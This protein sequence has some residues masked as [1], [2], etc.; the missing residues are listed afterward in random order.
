MLGWSCLSGKSLFRTL[1][2]MYKL[3]LAKRQSPFT[4]FETTVNPSSYG[5][6]DS[7]AASDIN[8][9][10]IFDP[11]LPYPI[12]YFAHLEVI[13]HYYT[14]WLGSKRLPKRL[15]K[16]PHTYMLAWDIMHS[17]VTKR[18]L[19]C[20]HLMCTHTGCSKKKFVIVFSSFLSPWSIRKY[21]WWHFPT[22]H[23][24]GKNCPINF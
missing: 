24:L 5:R 3:L 6:A 2:G 7:L 12:C 16:N 10:G 22:A 19:T 9:R 18:S 23:S 4:S 20:L 17:G 11:I 15:S 8:E 21:S 13:C 14:R 1:Q